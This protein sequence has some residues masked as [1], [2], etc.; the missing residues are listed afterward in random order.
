MFH[1]AK[2]FRG[3]IRAHLF[4]HQAHAVHAWI[5]SPKF[6]L[7]VH[8]H[9]FI[10]SICPKLVQSILKP[11]LQC[12]II[13]PESVQSSCAHQHT[14]DVSTKRVLPSNLLKCQ[15]HLWQSP[16]CQSQEDQ[17]YFLCFCIFAMAKIA[18][19][20]QICQMADLKSSKGAIL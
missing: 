3:L 17:C 15:R 6:V 9:N 20:L 12:I 10:Y 2:K 11:P 7:R 8:P 18:Q 5:L 14:Q 13:S 1:H 19:D 4:I 16:I